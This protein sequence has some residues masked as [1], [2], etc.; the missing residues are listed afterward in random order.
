[1]QCLAVSETAQHTAPEQLVANDRLVSGL[2]AM[3]HLNGA[4][5]E[6]GTQLQLAIRSPVV[7]HNSPSW[8]DKV[9]DPSNFLSRTPFAVIQLS[10]KCPT[11]VLTTR[12]LFALIV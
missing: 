11:S 2:A 7:R 9:L 12:L 5:I 4:L 3:S 8:L 1:M 6:T 10:Y